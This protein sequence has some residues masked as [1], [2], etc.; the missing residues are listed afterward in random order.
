MIE[1]INNNNIS[2]SYT[3]NIRKCFITIKGLEHALN[4]KHLAF[5]RLKSPHSFNSKLR[6]T[7]LSERVRTIIPGMQ[8]DLS[9]A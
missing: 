3:L 1:N 4:I 9:H 8:P 2:N 7:P 5:T 6:S